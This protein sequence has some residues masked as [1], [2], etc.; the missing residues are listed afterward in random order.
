MR[1]G[2]F[3]VAAALVLG[4]AGVSS[5]Q[6]DR[7]FTPLEIAIG[8]MPPATLDGMP[9]G[10]P[11]L[12]GAQ[13]TVAKRL[14]GPRDLLIVDAGTKNGMQLGQQFFVRRAGRRAGSGGGR[15][16]TTVGWVRLVAVNETTAIA[17][18]DQA[19]G[20]MIAG[21]YLQP[22]VAPAVPGNADRDQRTGEPDF[23]AMGRVVIG[24]EDRVSV[25]IGDF[26]LID[27]GSEHGLTPGARVAVYRAVGVS[28]MPLASIGEGV[29]ISTS[30]SVSVTRVTSARDAVISGDYVAVRK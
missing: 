22:F 14:F 24:N 26:M 15:S 12:I 11:H 27:R 30:G 17:V 2:S 21:D 23:S 8:C 20:G 19:C 13:D 7:V 6:P 9:D 28:G 1:P 10:V 25:G 16:A 5:A 18:V 3:V 29:V 4:S